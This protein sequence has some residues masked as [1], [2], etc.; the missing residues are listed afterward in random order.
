VIASTISICARSSAIWGLPGCRLSDG[1]AGLDGARQHHAID[2]RADHG[3][4]EIEPGRLRGCDLLIDLRLRGIDLRAGLVAR[5][6]GEVGIAARD[7]LLAR[8]LR[9][10]T[11][12]SLGFQPARAVA[13]LA[14][15][16]SPPPPLRSAPERAGTMRDDLAADAIVEVG[17]HL[18]DWPDI[19]LP[20]STV[21]IAASVPVAKSSRGC[22]ALDRRSAVGVGGGLAR[23]ADRNS[24][25]YPAPPATG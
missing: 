14:R 4:I 10:A 15:A 23:A 6:A 1:L 2:R 22:C 3:A 9:L 17:Q 12:I 20:T 19:W 13:R 18:G 16:L 21:E 24:R 11:E 7:Q 8:Q 5:G 25:R